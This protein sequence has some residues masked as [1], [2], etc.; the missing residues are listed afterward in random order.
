MLRDMSV[1]KPVIFEA[2]FELAQSIAGHSDLDSLCK[3]LF[4]SLKR[5]INLDGIALLLHDETCNALRMH[6]FATTELIRFRHESALLPPMAIVWPSAT[7]TPMSVPMAI[8]PSFT[9]SSS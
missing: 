2:L 6:A 8:R 4:R 1:D 5:V 9:M 7:L 3:A